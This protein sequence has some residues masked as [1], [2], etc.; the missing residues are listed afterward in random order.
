MEPPV[1]IPNTEVKR[2][3][4][5]GSASIGCARVGHCQ[6]YARCFGNKAPGFFLFA[7]Y[8]APTQSRVAS[9]PPP[10]ILPG[11][12]ARVRERWA[13]TE[14]RFPSFLIGALAPPSIRHLL[15]GRSP[16]PLILVGHSP[17]SFRRTMSR[18]RAGNVGA[19]RA[20]PSKFSIGASAPRSIRHLLEGRAPRRPILV[21]RSPTPF[22]RT[23]P[24]SRAR[25]V[26]ADRASPYK[27]FD[28][29]SGL[30]SIR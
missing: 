25:N 11:E 3:R 27:A 4:A 28:G 16:R 21:G 24:R 15:E 20:S 7:E 23:R 6:D 8:S 10:P 19:D 17:A 13:P 5:D 14:H 2:C 18:S 26:G 9:G 22:R 1:P 30:C 29:A 12:A